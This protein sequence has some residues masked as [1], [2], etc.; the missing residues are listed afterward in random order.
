MHTRTLCLDGAQET[1]YVHKYVCVCNT[2]GTIL[3]EFI[4]RQGLAWAQESN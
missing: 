4:P 2:T 3:Y 1:I